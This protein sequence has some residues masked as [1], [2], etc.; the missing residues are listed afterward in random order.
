MNI[1]R[2]TIVLALF[3][4]GLTACSKDE[5]PEPFPAGTATLYMMNEENGRTTLG[6]SDVYITADLRRG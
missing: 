4:I 1:T 2:L 6:N 5:G 3:A